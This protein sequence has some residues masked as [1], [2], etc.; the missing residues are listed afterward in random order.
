MKMISAPELEV[1]RVSLARSRTTYSTIPDAS[2][3][4][5]PTTVP[6]HDLQNERAGMRVRG[7]VDV[8]DTFANAVKSGRRTDS[9]VGHGHVVINGTDET[10]NLQMS[11]VVRLLLG[12]L[13]CREQLAN[14]A[15][16]LCTEDVC[17]GERAISAAYNECIDALLD[18]IMRRGETALARPECHR[19][20]GANQRSTL[21]TA[22]RP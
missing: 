19:A 17:T 22:T 7:G 18:H 11:V 12:D 15:W 4:R 20:S 2:H 1:V 6:P 13:A 5:K 14:E 21:R 10:D 9:K 16:P 3:E 8:V